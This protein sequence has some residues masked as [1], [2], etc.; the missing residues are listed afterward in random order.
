MG[1]MDSLTNFLSGGNQKRAT[2]AAGAATA[3]LNNLQT[4]DTDKMK[5]E[6]E[7][8]V[9]QGV[10]TPEEA[11]VYLVQQ[12]GMNGISLD[13]KLQQAQ[14]D[15]LNSLQQIS[16]SGGMLDSDVANLSRI[17]SDEQRAARGAREAIVQNAQARGLGGSG[18]ELM[19]QMQNQQD[20]AT[21]Q[22]QRDLDVAGMAQERALQSLISA[23][24]L[25]GQMQDRSFGQQSDIA[26]AN[27]EINRFN[28]Q[29]QQNVANLN[30]ANRNN[31]QVSNLAEKQRI[32]DT[33][34]AM[35]NQQQQ[36]NAQLAQQDFENKYKKAGGVA[37]ALQNQAAQYGENA[38]QN[39]NLIGSG[40][41]AGSSYAA[42]KK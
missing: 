1:I 4:P 5:Y 21:R 23:G 24:N 25:G 2:D 36:Y 35:K 41:Q 12:S 37:S 32:A 22:N 39:M 16:D 15:A 29:N 33:N 17:Q 20:S 26:R 13:P 27:D 8:M 14:M 11:Q 9:Q 18:I 28:A 6:L 38:K 7:L 31:A 34:N 40:L 42:A 3:A 19:Q 30:V 10:I